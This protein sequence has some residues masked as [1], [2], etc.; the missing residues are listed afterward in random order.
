MQSDVPEIF[1]EY[2]QYITN[3]KS[4]DNIDY[5]ALKDIFAAG[6]SSADFDKKTLGIFDSS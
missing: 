1:E 2:F 3:L 6:L 5:S 4:G